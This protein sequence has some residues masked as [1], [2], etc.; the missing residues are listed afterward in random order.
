MSFFPAKLYWITC[1]CYIQWYQSSTSD[2][3]RN[4]ANITGIN[5]VKYMYK[6]DAKIKDTIVKPEITLVECHT[7]QNRL[8]SKR[9]GWECETV[10]TV[11]RSNYITPVNTTYVV[12][13]LYMETMKWDCETVYV[14]LVI[15]FTLVVKPHIMKFWLENSIW[16]WRSRSNHFL[17]Q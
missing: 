1:K 7:Q 17:K 14:L 3:N 11:Q 13:L 2:K 16:P 15:L 10:K 6:C 12:L 4:A 9:Q 5:C 8:E